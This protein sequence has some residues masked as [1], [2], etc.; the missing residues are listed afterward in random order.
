MNSLNSNALNSHKILIQYSTFGLWWNRRLGSWMYSQQIKQNLCD[1]VMSL[2]ANIPEECGRYSLQGF[3]NCTQRLL[4]PHLSLY[5]CYSF[6]LQN[7]IIGVVYLM[8]LLYCLM[9][10]NEVLPT[11]L[12]FTGYSK[13]LG[14]SGN[15]RFGW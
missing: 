9:Y 8:S 1:A 5:L 3:I 13:Q 12:W 2:K 14:P 7:N 10:Y 6:L 11:I 4:C 15:R